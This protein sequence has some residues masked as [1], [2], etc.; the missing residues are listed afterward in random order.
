M[1]TIGHWA[2][3]VLL[4][5][6]LVVLLAVGVGP[7][8]GRYRLA[9][10]LSGSMAPGMPV[11]SVA[12]L[13]PEDPAAVRVGDVITFQAPTPDHPVVTHRVVEVLEGG[14]H[15]VVRTKGDANR[16]PDPW[17]A[18]L[19]GGRAWRRV[20]VIP[21]AG[22]A[23]RLLR[24]G[25][26]HH[27]TVQ[28]VPAV[29]LLSM[30]AAIWLPGRRRPTFRI[31]RPRLRFQPSRS[32]TIALAAV[33]I[34]AAAAPAAGMTSTTSAANTMSSAADWLPPSVSTTVIAKQTGYLAGSIKQGGTYYVYASVADSGNP[35]S[36]ISTVKTDVS[37]IT[38]GSTAVSLTSGSYSVNGVSYNYRTAALMANGTLS[39]TKSY[40]ITS[41]DALSYAQTQN[42]YSVSID[43]AAP[44]ATNISTGNGA[45][46]THG[47]AE[48]SDTITFTFSEPIDPE[49]ILSGWTGGSTNVVVELEDGGCTVVLCNDDTFQIYNAAYNA[50]LPLGSVDL[51]TG[52]YY[53]CSG[54]GVLCGKTPTAFGASGTASTMVQ[55]GSTITI[56]LGTNSG[57]NGI[58]HT[59]GGSNAM[60]WD[61]ITTPYDAAGN[62]ATGNNFTS[63]SGIQF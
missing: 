61:S 14:H 13:A 36:G 28:M 18:R 44:T 24:S 37:A 59:V 9:T 56:T 34:L 38:T 27:V 20:A 33:I 8:S 55:S 22:T 4:A 46:G 19:S 23:I 10:V 25:A 43:N 3:R 41:T 15:P 50:T 52:N 6:A 5:G 21:Y 47:L 45:G 35:A 42:G 2:V 29:L 12:V 54:I 1:R 58:L 32:R 16:A 48:A 57:G 49:S 39:G 7:M 31:P 40:T 26:V 53:G 11:G 17:S 63:A 30:L 60:V 51:G 62:A